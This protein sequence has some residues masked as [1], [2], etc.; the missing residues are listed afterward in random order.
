MRR[1]RFIA[2]AVILLVLA[3]IGCSTK[4][5]EKLGIELVQEVEYQCSDES[6]VNVRFYKLSDDSLGFVKVKVTDKE[7]YTL[8]QVIAASGVRYSDEYRIQ[9]WTKGNTMTLYEMNSNREW[10]IVKEGTIKE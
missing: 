8:P 4:P 7:E 6:I 9:F 10:E 2:I 1:N 3:F 5:K